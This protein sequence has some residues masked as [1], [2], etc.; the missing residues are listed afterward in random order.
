MRKYVYADFKSKIFCINTVY[1]LDI[2][3]HTY[4]SKKGK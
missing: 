4:R 3:I 1:V 2:Y